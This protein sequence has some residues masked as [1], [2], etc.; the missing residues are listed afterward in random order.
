MN[1]ILYYS[2]KEHLKLS[3]IRKFGSEMLQITENIDLRILYNL[4]YTRKPTTFKPK[5][6]GF[7]ARNTNVYKIRKLR[8]AI[9]SLLTTFRHQTLQFR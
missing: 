1:K 6:A 9:L 3:K 5:I 4:Y 7:F 8:R 2:W